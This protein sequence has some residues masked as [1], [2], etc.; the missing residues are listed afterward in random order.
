MKNRIR[1]GISVCCW[2]IFSTISL[3]EDQSHCYLTLENPNTI[4]PG[5]IESLSLSL[6]S[7]YVEN[8]RSIPRD[9]VPA[10]ACLYRVA[11]KKSGQTLFIA[12][13][14]RKM[15]GIGDSKLESF[16]GVQQA[17]LRALVQGSQHKKGEICRDFSAKIKPA[18][19]HIPESPY[20]QARIPGIVLP[21]SSKDKLPKG[22]CSHLQANRDYRHC[23]LSKQKIQQRDLQGSI[24]TSVNLEKA[25]FSGCNLKGTRFENANLEK[26]KFDDTSIVNADFTRANLEKVS[27][28]DVHFSYVSFLEANLQKGTF[29]G[30]TLHQANFSRANLQKA[31]FNET[32]LKIVDLSGA[33]LQKAG[34][35]GSNLVQ[36]NLTDAN[37]DDADFSKA[38]LVDVIR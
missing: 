17:F 22:I 5:I 21:P 20:S 11:V 32:T 3:A 35:P 26:A 23:N 33:N 34:F 12:I 1:I 9:G 2:L 18:C 29:T 24:F 14:G 38:T 10:D 19:E 13:S 31:Q 4:E 25:D 15:N 37:L 27:F 16:D 30:V 6:L 8:V 36:V 7:R 28:R